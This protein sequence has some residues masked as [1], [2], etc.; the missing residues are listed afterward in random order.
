MIILYFWMGCFTSQRLGVWSKI[1]MCIFGW[2]VLHLRGWS[3]SCL[4]AR[5]FNYLSTQIDLGVGNATHMMYE[6]MQMDRHVDSPN[7]YQIYFA[8]KIILMFDFLTS[9]I[10]ATQW[11][12][13][14]TSMEFNVIHCSTTNNNP[15]QKDIRQ[16]WAFQIA[17]SSALKIQFSPKWLSQVFDGQFNISHSFKPCL[18]CSNSSIFPRK[19]QGREC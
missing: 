18:Q 15:C 13:L 14:P 19:I 3:G 6:T 2:G 9:P 10:H 16:D 11:N 5:P 12:L 17:N 1:T 7:P 8:W 4:H